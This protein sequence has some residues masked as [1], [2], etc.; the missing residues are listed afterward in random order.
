MIQL[1]GLFS[2]TEASFSIHELVK[3]RRVLRC[4]RSI[5]RT[6]EGFRGVREDNAKHY[7]DTLPGTDPSEI[8]G[9]YSPEMLPIMSALAQEFAVCDCWF[10]SAPTQTS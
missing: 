5:Q 2:P 9:M 4:N 8:M 3:V 10:A 6:G 7:K 1:Q